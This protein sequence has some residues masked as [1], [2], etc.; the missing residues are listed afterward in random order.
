MLGLRI[1]RSGPSTLLALCT[2]LVAAG[3]VAAGCGP[4]ET[5][6]GSDLASKL[7]IPLPLAYPRA[8]LSET[9]SS[10]SMIRARE[11]ERTRETGARNRRQA[12]RGLIATTRWGTNRDGSTRAPVEQIG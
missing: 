5:E 3:L 2:S 7:E 8:P 9:P 1:M 6:T 11:N 4:G 12:H 10:D